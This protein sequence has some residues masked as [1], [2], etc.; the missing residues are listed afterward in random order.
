MDDA[1]SD[2]EVLGLN[3]PTH[4][5]AREAAIRGLTR[6]IADRHAG[7]WTRAVLE[8]ELARVRDERPPYL[9]AIE[10]WLSREIARRR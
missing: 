4:R 3:H 2:L 10:L 9:A 5:Q 1:A 6:R 7:S 8:R